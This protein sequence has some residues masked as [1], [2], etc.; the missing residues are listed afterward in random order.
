MP[1]TGR[2][3]PLVISQPLDSHTTLLVCAACEPRAS[4]TPSNTIKIGIAFR[5]IVRLIPP[6]SMSLF[7]IRQSRQVQLRTHLFSTA[8]D[9]YQELALMRI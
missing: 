5:M 3:P 1:A 8:T 7:A 6:A 9:S 4:K 2:L